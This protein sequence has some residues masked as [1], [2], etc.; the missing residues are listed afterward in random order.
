MR[1][2]SR[3]ATLL[4]DVP[5]STAGVENQDGPSL[6]LAESADVGAIGRGGGQHGV[7]VTRTTGA[8]LSERR[9]RQGRSR[10]QDLC[11][12]QVMG[13]PVSQ[14]VRVTLPAERLE[15]VICSMWAWQ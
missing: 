15:R 9:P 11:F 12:S 6:A 13:A 14:K 10:P 2:E 8:G 4:H 7:V 5:S 1:L 3:A